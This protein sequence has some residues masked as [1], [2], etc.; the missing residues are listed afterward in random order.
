[1]ASPGMPQ[2]R[3]DRKSLAARLDISM[4]LCEDSRVFPYVY[5]GHV[6]FTITR[7]EVPPFEPD[8]LK[9]LYSQ[10]ADHVAMRIGAGELAPGA[11]LPAERDLAAEYGVSYHTAR[12]AVAVLRD[13]GLVVTLVGHG[14][15][16]ARPER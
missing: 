2:P 8:P 12:K 6:G 10:V 7:M 16:V 13:R 3:K 11:R 1:M 9:H 15:F 14:T 5:A 4:K